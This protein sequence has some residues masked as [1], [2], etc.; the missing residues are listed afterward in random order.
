MRSRLRNISVLRNITVARQHEGY[1]Q[2]QE[3][4]NHNIH[5]NV[6]HRRP[7]LRQCGLAHRDYNQGD[8]TNR[9][10]VAHARAKKNRIPKEHEEADI[11]R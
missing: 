6:D 10:A 9:L 2:E 1:D 11:G 8:V 7:L 5:Y 4:I 3:V